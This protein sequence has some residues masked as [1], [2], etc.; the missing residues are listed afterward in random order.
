MDVPSTHPRYRS[1]LVRDRLARSVDA[2]VTHPTGLIAH[3]RGEA[4]DYLQGERT[5][6]PAHEAE[7]AAA[8]YLLLARH[9]VI[10]VN[11]NVA[12]LCPEAVADVQRSTKARVEV[13]LFHRT[14]D[15]VLRIVEEL[16]RHGCTHVLGRQATS[17][18]PGL[19]HAR[20]MSETS[21]V[22]D[23]DVVLVPLED[24]DRAEALVAMGK[25]VIAVDLNPLSRT[26]KAATLAVVDEVSRALPAIAEAARRFRSRPQE[27]MENRV[28]SFDSATNLAAS[29]RT[30]AR[31]L[32][33]EAAAIE[34]SRE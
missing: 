34:R 33:E 6:V 17:R 20:S 9:P 12:A 25:T 2:G 24:G 14:E 15:R 5:T 21:G 19:A 3:G 8:C 22:V 10:S 28:R 18:I 29:L 31:H 32:E 7:E 26:A 4:F 16:E 27:E 30:M 11:G 23:A 1:L 13:N